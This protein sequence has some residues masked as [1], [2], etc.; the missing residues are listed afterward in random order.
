MIKYNFHT[1]SDLCDGTDSLEDYVISAIDN[2]FSAIGFTPHSPLSFENPWSIKQ[3]DMKTYLE[4]A[5]KLKEKYKDKIDVY[6]GLEIDYIPGY[7]DDFSVFTSN[8]KLDYCIGSVHLVK[9][10]NKDELWFIDGKKEAYFETIKKFFNGNAKKAVEAF[11]MQSI[12]MINTQK[13]DIIGH[14][15]KVKMH[16]DEKLFS[17]SESWYKSLV[18]ETLKAVSDNNCIVEL[19]TRGVYRGK[20]KEFFPSDFVLKE[21]LKMDIPVMI[22]TD[23]HKPEQIDSLFS[24]AVKKLKDIGFKKTHTPFFSTEL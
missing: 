6:I 1:H 21:C 10:K 24:T 7:S 18:T 14:L 16:N 13:P 2:N 11:Y 5:S 17:T 22:N 15:D 20:T 23:A 9:I 12:E 19:N 8:N 4:N 3:E